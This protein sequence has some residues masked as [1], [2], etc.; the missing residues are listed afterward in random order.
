IQNRGGYAQYPA[1][2]HLVDFHNTQGKT[3]V[4]LLFPPPREINAPI[5]KAVL[6]HNPTDGST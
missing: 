6:R 1:P 2:P 3:E 4:A 5:S